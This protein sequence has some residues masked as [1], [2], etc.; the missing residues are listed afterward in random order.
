[1]DE[2]ENKFL[3]DYEIVC[4]DFQGGNDR[5]PRDKLSFISATANIFVEN[6]SDIRQKYADSFKH[7]KKNRQ[8]TWFEC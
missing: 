3:G 1:M 2:K 6:N 4:Y 7:Y 8:G 5:A